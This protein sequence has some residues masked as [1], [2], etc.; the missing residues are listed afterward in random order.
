MKTIQLIFRILLSP[1]IFFIFLVAMI[2]FPGTL[3]L[4]MGTLLIIA[5]ALGVN[6]DDDWEDLITMSTLIIWFPI[7][8]TYIWITEAK[9]IE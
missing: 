8:N 4:I 6:I 5:K 2:I 7:L 1:L 3:S 9:F